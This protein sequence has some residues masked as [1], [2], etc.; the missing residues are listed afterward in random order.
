MDFRIKTITYLA[1]FFITSSIT[2]QNNLVFNKVL[3]IKLISGQTAEVPE[4]KTWKIESTSIG[5]GTTG[6]PSIFYLNKDIVDYGD[7]LTQP[8][9]KWNVD[10]GGSSNIWLQ[11]GTILRGTGNA[12]QGIKFSIIEFNIEPI[13]SSS[14]TNTGSSGVSSEGL[15]FSKVI[16]YQVNGSAPTSYGGP[17]D[18]I[19]IPEGKVWKITRVTVTFTST[20][21]PYRTR[22]VSA[23]GAYLGD[24]L[25]FYRPATNGYSNSS[26]DNFPIWINSGLKELTIGRTSSNEDQQYKITISA[27]EYNE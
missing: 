9:E 23:T 4:G 10:Y 19:E 18:I 13:S 6:A 14:G 7:P 2:A 21:Y 24:I 17:M 27:I 20:T 8:Q 15:V 5:T 12:T 16:N 25:I 26:Y 3:T 22:D 11:E 1:L